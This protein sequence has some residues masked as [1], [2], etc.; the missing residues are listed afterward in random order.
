MND[1][2]NSGWNVFQI[3]QISSSGKDNAVSSL[4]P[5]SFSSRAHSWICISHSPLLLGRA[6]GLDS[7]QWGLMGKTYGNS[8]PG[9]Y[10]SS[11]MILHLFSLPLFNDWMQRMQ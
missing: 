5:C 1:F 7:D 4:N 6:V 10:K 8:K 3:I 9:S 2:I 11:C